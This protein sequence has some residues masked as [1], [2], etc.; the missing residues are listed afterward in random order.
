[1]DLALSQIVES[2]IAMR[3]LDRDRLEYA[4]LRDA[5]ASSKW[6]KPILVRARKDGKYEIIDGLHRYNIAKELE[7][8]TIPVQLSEASDDEA[9]R[10]A[11]I[12]N[13]TSVSPKPVEYAYQLRRL[14][15]RN[16][17]WTLGY[18]AGLVCQTPAW[19]KQQLDLLRLDDKIQKDVDAGRINLQSA[20]VLSLAPKTWQSEY[21]E[22]AMI[23]STA[24]LK[25]RLIPLLREYRSRIMSG[26]VKQAPDFQPIATCRPMTV[27]KAA[28]DKPSVA[29]I[30]VID[31]QV[32]TLADA[33][34]LG[35]AWALQLDPAAMQ[36]QRLNA[37]RKRD[38]LERVEARRKKERQLKAGQSP[39]FP[40]PVHSS[41]E[42]S[43][44]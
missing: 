9:M 31:G 40:H 27:L 23:C 34:R 26:K 15:A 2:E 35:V 38:K 28:L 14:A 12:S 4:Q 3:F 25:Q 11:I 42:V 24:E 43:D 21:R 5:I 8:A 13:A 10:L 22:E 37:A 32:T 16:P 6:I 39:L 30:M 18:L 41:N 17:E 19:V 44:E 36:Q 29:D 1:M 7:W 33:F 20:Y